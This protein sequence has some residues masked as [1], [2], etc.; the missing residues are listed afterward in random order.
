MNAYTPSCAYTPSFL[1]VDISHIPFSERAAPRVYDE[2]NREIN[3]APVDEVKAKQTEVEYEKKQR[4]VCGSPRIRWNPLTGKKEYRGNW[5]CGHA[6][7]PVC[8]VRRGQMFRRRLNDAHKADRIYVQEVD[9]ATAKR[10][11]TE[12]HKE[13]VLRLPKDGTN[14]V[15]TKTAEYGGRE[16]TWGEINYSI[17]WTELA[18]LDDRR[19]ASGLLG[20]KDTSFPDD[21]KAV[22]VL[23]PEIGVR[24]KNEVI[25]Q[26]AEIAVQETAHLDPKTKEELVRALKARNSAFLRALRKLGVSEKNYLVK[27]VIELIR[28]EDLKWKISCEE[29]VDASASVT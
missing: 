14:V 6:D 5:Y 24:A 16:V 18:K 2:H 25:D 27:Y 8:Q 13:N 19:N 1:K 9:D 20:K 3:P 11:M 23:I 26:A 4:F 10:I 12:Q 22:P 15:F 29:M 28:V 17:D 21:D 7:C